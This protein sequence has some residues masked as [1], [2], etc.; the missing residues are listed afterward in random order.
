MLSGD[1][2]NALY[3]YARENNGSDLDIE[4]NGVPVLLIQRYES[5]ERVLRSHVPRYRKN[6]EWFR[7]AL[8]Y[9]R[10]SED[11]AAWELRRKLTHE[12]FTHFDRERTTALARRYGHHA[13]RALLEDS[14]NGITRI[15]DDVLRHAT[16]SVL[17]ENFLG[18]PFDD[19]GIHIE[20]I[21]E[22][23]ELGSA[24]SFVP[25]GATEVLFRDTLRRLPALRREVLKDFSV[26]RGNGAPASPM[27][28]GLLAADGDK[29]SGVVLEHELLTFL[30]AGAET[31]AASA[32]WALY[33]LARYPEVQ[34]ALRQEAIA[35]APR[36]AEMG[37]SALSSF[38]GLA[39]FISE[40]LR[41]FPPTPII[42]RLAVEADQINDREIAPGQNV[43][44]SFVGIQ[45][46]ERYRADPWQL[47]LD[48]KARRGVVAGVHTAFSFGPRI[49]GGKQFALVE[50]M[51]LMHTM[52]LHARYEVTSMEPPRFRWKAQ[53]LHE[54]G[55]PVRAVPL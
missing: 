1:I 23:M 46:D 18:I 39:T 54:K 9:S 2:C 34:E 36:V 25:S 44:I 17:V 13:V 4:L 5:A 53:M 50:L 30:A 55:Q 12:H 33:L 28:Q 42:A 45:H 51:A 49:C 11:G 35:I 20:H 41:M 31:S 6:M 37:W 3:R 8:G 52:L 19:T 24:Y 14:Q 26:F 47:S 21:S 38:G 16:M 27:L 48:R 22:L 32:G 29:E 40:T 10:F 15:N 7:Q 43:L